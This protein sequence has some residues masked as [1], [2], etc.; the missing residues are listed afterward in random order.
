MIEIPMQDC[1]QPQLLEMFGFEPQRP[2]GETEAA[3]HVDQAFQGH[4]LGRD[5]EAA[6]QCIEVDFV[7]VER[8][9][10]GEAG[11]AAFGHFALQHDGEPRAPRE[12]QKFA[13]RAHGLGLVRN[14]L[15]LI[16]AKAGRQASPQNPMICRVPASAGTSR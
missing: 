9:D 7:A 14:D 3:R 10:H 1:R 15:P 5:R 12:V 11:E 13:D 16:P 6:A 2:A 4:A 8:G